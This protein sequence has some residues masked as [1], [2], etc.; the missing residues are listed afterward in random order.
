M[1]SRLIEDCMLL[2][3]SEEEFGKYIFKMETNL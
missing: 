1:T 2:E 3:E